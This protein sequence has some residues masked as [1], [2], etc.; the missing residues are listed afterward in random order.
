M[1]RLRWS[2]SNGL[3]G[4][5]ARAGDAQPAEARSSQAFRQTLSW[6]VVKQVMLE[7]VTT[8]WWWRDAEPVG[9][10]NVEDVVGFI[11]YGRA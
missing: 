1:V 3:R 8:C 11:V 5:A 2:C 10:L 6:A 9:Y 7:V 4:A